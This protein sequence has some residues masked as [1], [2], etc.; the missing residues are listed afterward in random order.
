MGTWLFEPGHTAAM[1]RARS[2]M[3]LEGFGGPRRPY[4]STKTAGPLGPAV[5]GDR[6]ST[7]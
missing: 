2:V 3:N 1:F 7:N 5:F 4:V 6:C